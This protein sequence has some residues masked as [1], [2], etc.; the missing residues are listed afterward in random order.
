MKVVLFCG[1]FGMRMRG[2]TSDEI[3]K[4]MQLVG[5]RPLLWHVMRYYAHFGHRE[6]VLCL[7]HGAQSIKQFFLD[8]DELLGNDLVLSNGHVKPL[9]ADVSE[10]EITFVDTGLA[11]PIGERLRQVRDHLAGEEIFLANYADVLCDID[12]DSMIQP[13]RDDPSLVASM[14]AVRPQESFHVLEIDQNGLVQDI[15]PVSGMPIWENGGFLVLRQEIFDHL[16]RGQDLVADVLNTLARDQRVRAHRYTGF[17]KAADT[18]KERAE[19]DRMWDQGNHPW[20]VWRPA[21]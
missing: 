17:W 15:A 20:A 2:V 18:F 6:F 4:P 8:Y 9:A 3:P 11:S 21:R 16:G 7:G 1:G 13:V 10:W 12:L 19:L 5:S 14:I